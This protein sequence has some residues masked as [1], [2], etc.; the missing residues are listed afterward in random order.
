M[1]QTVIQVGNSIGVIIPQRIQ[2]DLKVGDKV[3]LDKKQD[4]I[5][6]SPVKTQHA[7]GVDAKF[8]K[9]VDDFITEHE[10]V[11]KALSTR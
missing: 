3:M 9:M 6:I 5:V 10:D 4:T 2:S 11:L 1:Q 8:M 7:G